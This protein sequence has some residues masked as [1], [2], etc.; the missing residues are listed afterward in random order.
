M[1]GA[2]ALAVTTNDGIAAMSGDAKDAFRIPGFVPEYT[3][4]LFCEGAGACRWAPLTCDPADIA[5]TD[6][7]A[8]EPLEEDDGSRDVDETLERVLTC[9]PGIGVVPGADAGH[10]EANRRCGTR[11]H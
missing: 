11:A 10:L 1:P 5:T 7:L 2:Q 6:D 3:R 9:D 8:L 4:P